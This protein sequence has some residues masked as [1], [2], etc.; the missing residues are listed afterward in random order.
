MM[1]YIFLSSKASATPITLQLVRADLNEAIMLI[2]EIGNINVSIDDSINSYSTNSVSY[3]SNTNS[4][5]IKESSDK[6]ETITMSFNN[7]EA[8]EALKLIAKTKDLNIIEEN[9]IFIITKKYVTNAFLNTYVLPIRYGDAEQLRKAVVMILGSNEKSFG[10]A[11]RDS[12]KD[13][14]NDDT[15]SNKEKWRVNLFD[16]TIDYKE[17]RDSDPNN[18]RVIINKETNSLIIKCTVLE[19]EKHIE[20]TKIEIKR[21]II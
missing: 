18:K 21:G 15:D 4:F 13:N 19:Y 6:K 1:I 8:V 17:Y 14:D 11:S 20:I 16:R 12:L 5:T 10:G 2:A 9:E 7:I 3:N